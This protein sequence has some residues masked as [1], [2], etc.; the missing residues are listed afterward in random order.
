MQ[1]GLV[2]SEMCIRDSFTTEFFKSTM[3]KSTLHSEAKSMAAEFMGEPT[4]NLLRQYVSEEMKRFNKIVESLRSKHGKCLLSYN[5]PIP[6]FA[7]GQV[8]KREIRSKACFLDAINRN[9]SNQY[10][11]FMIQL[12]FGII[13]IL[14]L[15]FI[16]FKLGH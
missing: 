7:I 1:R 11:L 10:K 4:I 2:G 9:L 15:I 6:K 12:I 14:L 13:L 16:L 3:L 8:L 5:P